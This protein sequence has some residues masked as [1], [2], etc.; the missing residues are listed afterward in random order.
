MAKDYYEILGVEKGASKEDIKR[1]YKKLAK[2]FHPDINK[3]P[4][5]T[6]RFKEISEA[7]SV[8]GDDQKR[9]QYDQY[10]TT[11]DQ[12]AG[13]G[14]DFGDFGFSGG[15]GDINID[16]IFESFF[17]GSFGRSRRSHR[18]SR[19][20]DLQYNLNI[21]L[22]DAAFGAEK[23]I[24]F[25]RNATCDKCK[26]TGAESDSDIITCDV[27]NGSGTEKI[28]KRTPFGMFQTTSSCS[29]CRGSGKSIKNKCSTCDGLGYKNE[30]TKI[31]I[32]IPPGS[33]DGTN[34]RLSGKGEAGMNGGTSGDLYVVLNVKE[35][36]IFERHG[37]DIFIETK[38]NFTTAALG[39]EIEVPTLEG[40]ASLKI[41]SGSQ[42]G[43]TFR[44]KGKGITHLRGFGKGDQ[45][46]KINIEV[47]TKLSKRQKE[48]LEEFDKSY[49]KKKGFFSH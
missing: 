37:D 12:S 34:L 1:S 44:M 47:P 19:G 40:K 2:Q 21:E 7:A 25:N 49:K 29:K 31:T 35:H 6:K 24:S 8:L 17:G 5:A 22:E 18:S 41:P 33:K 16:D 14:F 11:Y 28:V 23:E 3:D 4:D 9:A 36:D 10:G 43:T 45:M 38:I 48:L 13:H 27:C 15:F 32:Q 46:I 42:P 20:S 26:G 39:G 30:L